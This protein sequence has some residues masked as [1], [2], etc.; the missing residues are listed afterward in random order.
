V[1]AMPD[2]DSLSDLLSRQRG[3][4]DRPRRASGS[5]RRMDDRSKARILD[6]SLGVLAALRVL[7]DVTEEVIR[8]RRNFLLG[9]Q[10]PD[11]PVS[12]EQDVPTRVP[13]KDSDRRNAAPREQIPLSY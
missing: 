7:T 12:G 5:R 13:P 6:A 3:L 2:W 1:T 10:M 8:E 4:T 9:V 11:D